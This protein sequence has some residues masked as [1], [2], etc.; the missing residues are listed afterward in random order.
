MVLI[1]LGAA[2][3][4]APAATPA[5]INDAIA[6]AIAYLYSTEKSGNWEP[7]PADPLTLDSN[8]GYTEAA[9][10]G[11]RTA[12]CTYALLAAGEDPRVKPQLQA[13]INWLMKADLHGTYAVALRA[14]VWLLIDKSPQRDAA[15]DADAQFL[16]ASVIQKGP[17]AGFYGYNFGIP[18]HVRK[19]VDF[20]MSGPPAGYWYD[21]SNSQYGVL[22]VWAAEQA[23]ADIPEKYWEV[24]DKAWRTAQRHDGGW[25]YHTDL[26][27]GTGDEARPTMGC[28]G[29]ATLFITQ[30]Y[31]LRQKKWEPCAGGSFDEN[32][33]NGLK[34]VEKNIN[35]LMTTG[36]FYGMY[37]VERIATA[38]GRRYFGA[39]DW[40]QSGADFAVKKQDPKTGS[41][42]GTFGPIADTCFAL[43]FLSRGRAPLMMNKLQYTAA[44]SK[45]G[46]DDT[47]KPREVEAWNERPRD[48]ANLA[49]WTGPRI[50]TFL[51]WQT[52]N[53]S[54]QADQLHEAPILYIS[55]N[56]ALNFSEDDKTKLRTF[57]EQGGMI[58]GT[59]DCGSMVFAR[60]FEKLG[61]NLFKAYEFR[62]LPS[63]HLIFTGEEYP[64]QKWRLHPVVKAMSNG[65]RE[66][67]ILLPVGDVGRV[68]QADSPL[69]REFFELGANI[70]L[71]STER[72]NLRFKGE[73]Y[74]VLPNASTPRKHI[75]I[76]RLES[77][78]NWDPEPGGWTRLA[79]IFHNSRDTQLDIDPV[80]LGAGKLAGYSIADI[81]GTGRIILSEPQRQELKDFVAKGGTLIVDAA[82]GDAEF[83]NSIEPELKAIFGKAG[84][85]AMEKP[86]MMDAPVFSAGQTISSV[87]YRTYTH[88]AAVGNLSVARI[89]GIP[90]GNRIGVFYSRMDISAG[91]V[92]EPVDGVVGYDPA[93]A[94]NLM[95][96][97]IVYATQGA[98]P[99]PAGAANAAL[100]AERGATP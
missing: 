60:S 23:G 66:I 92:G 43:L 46:D 12:I 6:K 93:S 88:R 47:D 77:A 22:G 97:M 74:V 32:I 16:L 84:E 95:T 67:M 68:W 17:N 59:A 73:P 62:Q 55:G 19:V 21:R 38:S 87:G 10:Y 29:V 50:E 44:G 54:V 82:G 27:G 5:Q 86:L 63:G 34:Y 25:N 98:G 78:G 49:R 56:E 79:A 48:V 89:Y 31:L 9:Q 24:V 11:G 100:P 3:R 57:V 65:V 70:F 13:A 15:R 90:S 83:A 26:A 53:L 58:L 7:A 30:D 1:C 2:A 99:A 18:G 80:K 72:Q 69:R 96:N 39:V 28:A 51:N 64:A 37:G 45:T 91:L 20:G 76:A 41:F 40:F 14:Q 33:E 85:A 35:A 75:R 71:Y 61:T 52:V 42:T 4:P 8:G 81:T 94:T 36:N